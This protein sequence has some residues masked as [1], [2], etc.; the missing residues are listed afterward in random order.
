LKSRHKN[1]NK[2]ANKSMKKKLKTQSIEPLLRALKQL[3]LK[4]LT[5]MNL[6]GPEENQRLKLDNTRTSTKVFSRSQAI[7]FL[8]RILQLKDRLNLL[9]LFLF[10]KEHLMTS[11]KSSIKRNHKS[12]FT[13]GRYLSMMSLKNFFLSISTS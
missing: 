11:L 1:G 10:L 7:L 3:N 12:S 13:S 4:E 8:T 2:K 6:F 9:V 5:K